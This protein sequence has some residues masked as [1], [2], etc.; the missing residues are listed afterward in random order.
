MIKIDSVS[1]WYRTAGGNAEI[2][3][4]ADVSL[5]VGRGEFVSL[6]GP[7]G[8]GKSTLLNVVAGLRRAS[9][10]A[11][12]VDGEQVLGPRPKTTAVVFQDYTLFPWR[13]VIKN[14]EAGLEFQGAERTTRQERAARYLEMVGLS[15]FAENYPRELS[16]G[17]KQRVAI[18]RA[19]SLEPE[20]L[21]LDEPFGAVD[22]Q[23]RMSLGI[24]LSHILAQTRKTI[25]FVTHSLAEAIFLA[26][27]VAVMTGRP[28][29]IKDI[30]VVDLPHPREPEVMTTDRFNQMRNRLFESLREEI[31]KS[32]G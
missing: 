27:R 7:S 1:M 32:A 16:G 19:L 18:A 6:I 24:Q 14:V 31:L 15:A 9:R 2:P 21:L 23:T 4:L 22:E 20:I 12:W 13:T 30:I 3:A 11:V 8:C 5:E 17:M 28:G 10:G 29:R 26:D 25:F